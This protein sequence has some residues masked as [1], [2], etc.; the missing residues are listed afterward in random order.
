[1]KSTTISTYRRQRSTL[2]WW[3][4]SPSKFRQKCFG[5]LSVFAFW[6]L[7]CY[8]GL[9]LAAQRCLSYVYFAVNYFLRFRFCLSD[10]SEEWHA[11]WKTCR[12]ASSVGCMNIGALRSPPTLGMLSIDYHHTNQILSNPLCSTNPG[13]LDYYSR[14]IQIEISV[15]ARSH[16]HTL[17]QPGSLVCIWELPV[18]SGLPSACSFSF[19]SSAPRRDD[20]VSP[21]RRSFVNRFA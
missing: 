5:L 15:V 17:R 1:M 3:E 13:H 11:A 20:F 16:L 2:F 9:I 10:W 19:W 14:L 21:A 7:M 12:A 4:R 6:F 8:Y 18:A